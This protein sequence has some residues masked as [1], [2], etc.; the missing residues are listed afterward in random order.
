MFIVFPG[1]SLLFPVVSEVLENRLQ[2][3]WA[4]WALGLGLGLHHQ[5]SWG[6]PRRDFPAVS[7]I[8]KREEVSIWR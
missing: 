4:T 6:R 7:R 1:C 2:P 8:V 5:E 3:G